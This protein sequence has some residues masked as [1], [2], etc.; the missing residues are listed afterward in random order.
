M[1]RNT[2][3]LRC[4][5]HCTVWRRAIMS[6]G[7]ITTVCSLWV[8]V[9][10]VNTANVITLCWYW[11][12]DVG[13]TY[14]NQQHELQNG[15]FC[16]INCSPWISAVFCHFIHFLDVLLTFWAYFQLLL[17]NCLLETLFT[18]ELSLWS[19]VCVS[20]YRLVLRCRQDARSRFAKMRSDVLVK[21]ELLD[22]KHGTRLHS[23]QS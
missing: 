11:Q 22:N 7:N 17:L 9:F 13:P 15:L 19:C 2:A 20:Y 18:L 21:L 10:V 6:T 3:T 4:R 5:S 8:Q 16:K 1:M 14:S 23:T 12:S